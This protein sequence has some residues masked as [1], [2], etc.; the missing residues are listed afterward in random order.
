MKRNDLPAQLRS[1]G[2]TLYLLL[3]VLLVSVEL[4]FFYHEISPQTSRRIWVAVALIDTIV[5]MTP[6]W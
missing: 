2:A 1:H 5:L 6:Y 4:F 3:S